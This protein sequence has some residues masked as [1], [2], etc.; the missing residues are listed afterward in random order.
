[1][2]RIFLGLV[3]VFI[4]A[5]AWL[6]YQK[7]AALAKKIILGAETWPGYL[8]LFVARDKGYFRE[9]G[10]NVEI[11]RYPGL[12]ELS[13]DYVAGKM[14][15]RANLTLDAVNEFLQGL[16]HKI[17][18]V[19]DHSKGSDAIW[20]RDDLKTVMDFRGKKVAFEFD[21]LEEFFITWVLK[22]H[23]MSVSDIVPVFGDPEK[24]V[25]ML[26]AGEADVAV[27]HE[28][29]LSRLAKSEH[30]HRVFSSAD[31]PGLVTDILTFRTDFVEA[32]PKTVEAILRAYFKGL[33][34]WKEHPEEACA[35]VAREFGDT[36][37]G[38][39]T[40]LKG[41]KML[42]EHDNQI[43]F[44]FAAGLKSLYGN[45]RQIGRFVLEH[46]AV[47]SPSINTDD[48]IERRFVQK[49]PLKKITM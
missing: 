16:D 4:L 2:K 38:I 29:Y 24:A 45:M 30:F 12:G 47:N 28:P 46:S 9:L 25:R 22:Q 37:D 48:L 10:L 21:T 27:S 42:D 44:T 32:Y 1:M 17:V 26:L 36:P 19:I 31:A 34:F 13:K 40:Q 6:G 43:A 20:A 41:I 14:Q 35:I 18:A 5:G 49:M 8:P 15:G 3:L 39:A 11:K 23:G 7:M 33:T